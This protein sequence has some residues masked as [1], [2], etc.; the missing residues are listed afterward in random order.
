MAEIRHGKRLLLAVPGFSVLPA[1]PELTYALR[2]EQLGWLHGAEPLQVPRVGPSVAFDGKNKAMKRYTLEMTMGTSNYIES[3]ALSSVPAEFYVALDAV[4]PLVPECGYRP[5]VDIVNR[6]NDKDLLQLAVKY[7]PLTPAR[8][9]LDVLVRRRIG[10]PA[11]ATRLLALCKTSA[12]EAPEGSNALIAS[13][14]ASLAY[15]MRTEA[16]YAPRQAKSP[17]SSSFSHAGMAVQGF[18]AISTICYSSRNLLLN[19]FGKQ[20]NYL[21]K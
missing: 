1:I 15:A 12:A 4:Q 8:F 11:L 3:R 16:R 6:L 10:A 20:V 14:I 18:S 5:C 7:A 9:A 21:R 19:C 13:G 17:V 2:H